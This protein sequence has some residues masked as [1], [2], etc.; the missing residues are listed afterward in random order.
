MLGYVDSQERLDKALRDGGYI[1]VRDETE[2]IQGSECFVIDAHTRYGQFSLWLDPKHGYHAAKI[3]KSAKEGESFDDPDRIIPSVSIYTGYLDVL[4]FTKV[5]DI[6]VPVKANAGFHRP[7]GSPAYYMAED[8][9][10]HRTQI[11]LNPNHDK[12]GSFAERIFEDPNNDPE[13]VNGTIFEI[14]TDRQ[15]VH[16][17]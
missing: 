14:E 3:R 5:D 6:W 10:Y 7:I 1:S 11:I 13:L 17:T 15:Y 16:H 9:R 12:M 2:T 4:E 8:K